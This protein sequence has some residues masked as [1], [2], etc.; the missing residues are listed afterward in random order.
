MNPK[1]ID[2]FECFEEINLS[3]GN[4]IKVY[5]FNYDF[6]EDVMNDWAN[7]F[8]NHYCP[9]QEIDFLRDGTGLSREEYLMQI[10]FPDRTSSFGPATRSGDFSEILVADY[11]EYILN[12][13]VPRTRYDRKTVR[14]ESIKG[15]DVL[16]FMINN[17]IGA[18]KDDC[19]SIFE[20]KAKFSGKNKENKL[21]EAVNDSVKDP[22]R[23]SE[24]LNAI[25]QRLLDRRDFEGCNKISRFLNKVDNPYRLNLGAVA[26]INDEVFDKDIYSL[27]HASNHDSNIDLIVI[28][29]VNMMTLI[30]ELYRRASKC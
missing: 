27:T 23:V 26:V 18:S 22:F 5:N 12:H 16:G 30:H 3:D 2:W 4:T 28:K 25:K 11:L 10:K 24:S 14:N 20:V 7:Y 8:R 21:Q 15:C 17:Q 1:H 9:D 29:G 13:Y 6:S 19:I